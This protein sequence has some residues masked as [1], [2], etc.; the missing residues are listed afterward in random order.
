MFLPFPYRSF[1]PK[2]SVGHLIS[3]WTFSIVVTTRERESEVRDRERERVSD[4][5]QRE[6][7]RSKRQRERIRSKRQRESQ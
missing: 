3:G 7:V 5:R 2:V 6:R 4:K 1:H